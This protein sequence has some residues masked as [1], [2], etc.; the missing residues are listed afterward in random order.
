MQEPKNK[1]YCATVVKLDSFSPLA[2]CDNLKAAK[3]FG[4]QVIVSKDVVE[5]SIGLFF[6]LETKLHANFLKNNNLF[7]KTDLNS[8]QTRKGFFEE[9]GRVRCVKLRGHKS[10]GI[11]LPL[12]FLSY[13]VEQVPVDPQPFPVGTDFDQIGEEVICSKYVPRGQYCKN[14]AGS[15]T[16]KTSNG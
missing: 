10:E 5:G 13:I 11:W 15:K 7:R 2:G 16:P 4:N 12:E 3:I 8:D 9:N 14:A 6:P 1:N